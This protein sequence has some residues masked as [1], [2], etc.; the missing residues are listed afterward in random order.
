MAR[1]SAQF[2][3]LKENDADL[4]PNEEDAFLKVLRTLPEKLPC[5]VRFFNRGNFHTVHGDDA[6]FVS[7]S[8]FG[9]EGMLKKFRNRNE[10]VYCTLGPSNLVTVVRELLELRGYRIEEYREVPASE[11]HKFTQDRMFAG[12]ALFR[13]AS[14]G[15]VDAFEEELTREDEG[16][17][18]AADSAISC[19]ISIRVALDANDTPQVAFA[20]LRMGIRYQFVVAEF[21]DNDSFSEL[22][23]AIIQ[24]N[25]REAL[26]EKV[27]RATDEASIVNLTDDEPPVRRRLLSLLRKYSICV[28]ELPPTDFGNENLIE[29]LN[30]L[31]KFK[32]KQEKN[33]LIFSEVTGLPEAMKCLSALV[34]TKMVFTCTRI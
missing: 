27:T 6:V 10:L 19:L 8:I 14:P 31:L 34:A 12:W 30:Q 29:I 16:L 26:I 20:A 9:T 13:K 15:N 32:K 5:T 17:A 25:P 3:P 23:R 33:C 18:P 22:A 1:Q 28:T 4:E 24:L 11:K 7:Q 2:V 21:I